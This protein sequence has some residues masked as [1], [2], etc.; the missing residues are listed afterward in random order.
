MTVSFLGKSFEE[1][2]DWGNSDKSTYRKIIAL[3]KDITRT[4]FSGLGKPEPLKHE[5][6]GCW[7]RRITEEH[8][9]VYKVEADVLKI[10]ACKYHYDK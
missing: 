3:I 6:S 9:L 5:L 2:T 7:S 1:F 4:P 8:R 10:Y